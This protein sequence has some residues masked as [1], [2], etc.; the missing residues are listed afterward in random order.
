[1][2]HRQ[3]FLDKCNEWQNRS[4]ED[5]NFIGDV[6]DGEVWRDLKEIGGRPFLALPNNLCLGLN[7]D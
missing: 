2:A 5:T 3:G 1:M 7:I 4:K 6:Y